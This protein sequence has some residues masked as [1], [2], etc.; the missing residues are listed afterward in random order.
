[1]ASN[2]EYRDLFSLK[3]VRLWRDDLFKLEEILV[4]DQSTDFL[5][6][7][8]MFDNATRPF[9]SFKEVFTDNNLPES[10]NKLR[11]KMKRWI[12]LEDGR[13]ILSGIDLC[14]YESYA[15]CQLHSIDKNWFLG[16]RTQI[17]EFVK[18]RTPW[19]AVLNKLEVLYPN[20]ALVLL[21]YS[22]I[23]YERGQY[24]YIILPII[25]AIMLFTITY[26][27][28]KQKLFPFVKIML[29]EKQKLDLGIMGWSAIASCIFTGLTF[30]Q[31]LI[32][33]LIKIW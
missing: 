5:D 15:N 23:E 22:Y 31:G 16:M 10:I 25:T 12:E 1:M 30:I 8:V 6:I 14:F 18:A 29:E 7:E 9:N 4:E 28:H 21:F 33:L 11:V 17:K 32:L 3:S 27:I 24:F 26:L 2:D 20:I 19:Y 13:E